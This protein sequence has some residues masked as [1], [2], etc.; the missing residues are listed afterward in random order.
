MATSAGGQTQGPE[1]MFIV[2]GLGLAAV[3]L[4]VL[5]IYTGHR[6][7]INGLFL[8]FSRLELLPFI[9][10][11]PRAHQLFQTIGQLQPRTLSYAQVSQAL[12]LSGQYFRWIVTPL[13]ALGA[14][15]LWVHIG[16]IEQFNR[17]FTMRSLAQHNAKIIP[18]LRPVVN[19]QRTIL[20][21][22]T[23]TGPWRVAESPMLFAVRHQIVT[24]QNG[25]RLKEGWFF[26]DTGLPKPYPKIPEGGIVFRRKVAFEVLSRRIGPV[27]PGLDP[28]THTL[29]E[30]VP[31]YIRGLVGAF[32]AFG[33]N[34]RKA[35]QH[36]LDTMAASWNESAA[37]AAIDPA[38]EMARNFEID[39]ADALKWMA[40][41]MRPPKDNDGSR[42]ATLARSM[43]IYLIGKH[44]AYL[45]V[46]IARLLT[47][48]RK[49]SGT[50]PPLEFLWLRP[51]NRPLWYL[52][53]PLGGTGGMTEGAA[54]WSHLLSELT[55]DK[56]IHTPDVGQGVKALRKAIEDEGWLRY[57]EQENP[58]K[59]H[60]ELEEF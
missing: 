6:D 17:T 15:R 52:L 3:V 54:T 38:T 46:W 49:N 29:P 34:N 51:T 24:Q 50:I 53:N 11:S 27:F 4:L 41:A 45:F 39:I 18:T 21:E 35:G 8:G 31:K 33:L 22:P 55:Y 2:V 60:D 30:S 56:A 9:A 25:D 13:F 36:I 1:D 12:F 44:D 7:G 43:Q 10:F 20:E 28:K 47:L 23:A 32:C 37:L 42:E 19:R 5:G 16:W 14:W 59:E 48:A 26:Q 58:S 40:K 57:A